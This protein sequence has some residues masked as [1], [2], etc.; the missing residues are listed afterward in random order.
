M[1]KKKEKKKRNRMPN[2]VY[3]KDNLQRW[4]VWITGSRNT[5]QAYEN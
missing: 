4:E 5:A 1:K 2:R 3:A